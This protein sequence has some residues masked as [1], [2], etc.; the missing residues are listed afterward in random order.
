MALEGRELDQVVSTSF[1]FLVQERG[2][3]GPTIMRGR[4]LSLHYELADDLVLDVVWDLDV[5]DPFLT[6]NHYPSEERRLVFD[7]HDVLDRLDALGGSPNRDNPYEASGPG[8]SDIGEG[9]R[10]ELFEILDPYAQDLKRT[11]DRVLDYVRSHP[12]DAAYEDKE[13]F[14][15][16]GVDQEVYWKIVD[17]G[18]FVSGQEMT[19]PSCGY[20]GRVGVEQ[21]NTALGSFLERVGFVLGGL[22]FISFLSVLLELLA[23]QVPIV[24]GI[25]STV[26][27]YI[28]N[29]QSSRVHFCPRCE[30]QGRDFVAL[31]RTET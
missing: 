2:A 19:C 15:I 25:L 17:S 27:L 11:Y 21:H 5:P 9:R 12:S 1:E 10:A 31:P 7:L 18:R 6:L 23:I 29:R 3:S 4:G 28:A 22:G 20:V 8:N 24:L 16:R 30:H 26:S 13:P 14:H